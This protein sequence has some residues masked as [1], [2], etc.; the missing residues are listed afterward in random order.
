LYWSTFLSGHRRLS[1]A[2][3]GLH[4]CLGPAAR[5]NLPHAF[6][7]VTYSISK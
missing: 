6:V 7:R 2:L 5:N 1:R 4:H 3:H